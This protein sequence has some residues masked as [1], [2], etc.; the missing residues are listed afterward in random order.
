MNLNSADLE[1]IT[2][3]FML[4]KNLLDNFIEKTIQET[5]SEISDQ[6]L[7]DAI[8]MTVWDEKYHFIMKKCIIL[9]S[10]IPKFSSDEEIKRILFIHLCTSKVIK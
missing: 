8:R 5:H 4:A 10:I 6:I 9:S 1:H 2:H 3:I 7:K